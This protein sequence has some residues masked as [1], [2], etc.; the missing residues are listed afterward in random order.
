MFLFTEYLLLKYI[1]NTEN[2]SNQS[3]IMK[4]K[5]FMKFFITIAELGLI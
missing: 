4:G 1:M 2:I 5:R 3:G